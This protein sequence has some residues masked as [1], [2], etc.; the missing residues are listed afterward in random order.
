M[1]HCMDPFLTDWDLG[2]WDMAV[3]HCLVLLQ[4][5]APGGTLKRPAV[6]VNG[7]YG[8]PKASYSKKKYYPRGGVEKS[9]FADLFSLF[10]EHKLYFW[11]CKEGFAVPFTP[12]HSLFEDT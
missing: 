3:L 11:H 4:A 7:A 10:F 2:V 5:G 12:R 6:K 8:R 9:T 1:P